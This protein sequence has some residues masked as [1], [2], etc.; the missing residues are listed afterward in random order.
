M[1]SLIKLKI[2]F[3]AAE[4]RMIPWELMYLV[5]PSD[6]DILPKIFKYYLLVKNPKTITKFLVDIPVKQTSIY[7]MKR[8]DTVEKTLEDPT[9]ITD[10]INL[11]QYELVVPLTIKRKKLSN[12]E[13]QHRLSYLSST[14]F[15]KEAQRRGQRP[16]MYTSRGSRQ[17]DGLLPEVVLHIH[18]RKTV[19]P[20]VTC[21][22]FPRKVMDKDACVL[23]SA[24]CLPNIIIPVES[25]P[26]EAETKI[27]A[28]VDDVGV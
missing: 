17:H 25:E 5:R 15:S 22:N 20:C 28:E 10:L 12:S 9:D 1:N 16:Y 11:D 21:I 18:N 4:A 3:R 27:E 6:T 13:I 26:V 23:G 2:N 19:H 7:K 24:D 14:A 8:E